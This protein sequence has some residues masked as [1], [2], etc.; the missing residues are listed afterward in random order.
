LVGVDTGSPGASLVL[1]A[2][3]P[4]VS[5][6]ALSTNDIS[7]L[8]GNE[9]VVALLDPRTG[10]SQMSL[11]AKD[12]DALRA[13]TRRLR[14]AGSYRGAQL[15]A[16]PRGSA[17]AVKGQ[18]LVAASDEPTVRRALDTGADRS[19]HLTPAQFDRRLAGLSPTAEVRA[20]FDPKRAV[21]IT[22]LP[23]LLRTRWGRSLTNGAAE[24][25]TT[26][27]G[28]L[29]VPF[30]LQTDASRL[31]DQDLPF[32]TGRQIPQIRGRAPL[33]IGVRDLSRMIAFLRRVDPD[34]LGGLDTL[35][36]S[37]PGFLRV[38]VNGLLGG[39]TNDGT[40]SSADLLAHF[41][42]RTEPQ[43]PGA[44]RR[45][46]DRLSTLSDVLKS[47]GVGN[48]QLDE[49]GGEYRL[50]IDGDLAA[51]VALFGRTLVISDDPGAS[52]RA[53]A[54][55]PAVPAPAGGARGVGGPPAAGGG[56]AGARVGGAGGGGA[57]RGGR[58]GAGGAPRG[59]AAAPCPAAAP[60]P[61]GR[62]RRLPRG[63][64]GA[65]AAPGETLA[66]DRR[67]RGWRGG[68]MGAAG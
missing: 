64:A 22:R 67:A 21:V 29:R 57:A 68:A 16:G 63:G 43:D 17:A 52:L 50:T 54:R 59:G 14:S 37:L 7:P 2:L 35:Q 4:R 48:M 26:A 51:R 46:L 5:G 6:G 8:L 11:V 36:T 12:P 15:F 30:K 49:R 47:V 44:W 25:T 58:G 3:V 60:A 13:L 23:G 32:A 41:V 40:I 28:G 55:A 39:L 24:L 42:A 33:L 27:D 56:G 9:A 20:V 31:T 38:N 61:A 53:A 34:R 10:R 1:G 45:P 18:T 65:A 62:A 19:R 66:P